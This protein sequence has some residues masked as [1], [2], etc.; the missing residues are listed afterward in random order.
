MYY[1]LWNTDI[2]KDCS[3][4]T[5]LHYVLHKLHIPSEIVGY[6]L[7]HVCPCSSQLLYT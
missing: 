3:H 4:F 5:A 2:L 7:L 6:F 1:Q